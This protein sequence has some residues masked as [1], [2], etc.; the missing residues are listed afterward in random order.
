MSDEKRP[1]WRPTKYRPEFCE[2]VVEAGRQGKSLTAFAGSIEVARQT[3]SR[4]MD[5]HEDFRA[6]ALTAK[7]LAGA[8]W[9]ERLQEVGRNGGGNGQSTVA[10]FGVKNFCRDDYRDEQKVDHTSSDGSMTPRKVVIVAGEEGE[11][12]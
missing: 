10:V 2:M 11:E 8:W 12:K 7:A 6:A 1:P 9:E 3:V 5:Q 4:W